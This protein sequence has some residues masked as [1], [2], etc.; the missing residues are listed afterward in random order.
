[1]MVSRGEVGL[2]VAG[3]GLAS[4]VINQEV[5]S[6]MVIMVLVTTMVTPLLLRL[7]FPKVEEAECVEVFE[8][9]A[10]LKDSHDNE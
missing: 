6:I 2:I 4:N 5:F 3:V 10:G 9:F 8:E 7:T 1:G